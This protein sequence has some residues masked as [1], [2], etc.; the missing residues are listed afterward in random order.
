VAE[1]SKL[2]LD[3]IFTVTVLIETKDFGVTL[4]FNR[5]NKHL[6]KT[7]LI[8]E[9]VWIACGMEDESVF[10]FLCSCPSLISLRMRTFSKQILD[11]D[12]Y[13]GEPGFALFSRSP[14]F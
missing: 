5:L 8:D 3:E 4:S 12:E 10:N 1:K 11:V 2:R 6:H 13:E 9:P 14:F 7:S